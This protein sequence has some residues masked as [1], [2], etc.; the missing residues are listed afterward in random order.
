VTRLKGVG[1]FRESFILRI[2]PR[3]LRKKKEGS[4][5]G[6]FHPEPLVRRRDFESDAE[7]RERGASYAALLA[8]PA[9]SEGNSVVSP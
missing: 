2:I 3:V 8:G 6:A 7:W 9:A 4:V 5:T 1:C